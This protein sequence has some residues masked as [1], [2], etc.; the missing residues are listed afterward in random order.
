MM[1]KGPESVGRSISMGQCEAGFGDRQQGVSPIRSSHLAKAVDMED[2]IVIRGMKHH[3]MD[4]AINLAA[5]EG[6]NPGLNDA[7]CFYSTDPDGFFVALRDDAPVGCISAVSYGPEFGFIGFFVVVPELRGH[8]IGLDLGSAAMARLGDRNIGID[9]VEKKVKNYE[10]LGFKLAYRNIRYEGLSFKKN[11]S[12]QRHCVPAASLAVDKLA[13]YDRRFFPAPRPAFLSRWIAQAGATSFAAIDGDK[14]RGLGVIRPC[15]SGYKIGPLFADDRDRAELLF[16][17]LI[18]SI[19]EGMPFYMDPPET[20]ADALALCRSYRMK[21]VFQTARMY[22][23]TPPDI[24]VNNIYGV[25]SF[26]LG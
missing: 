18:A 23:K 8:R 15:R 13:Q 26:E 7:E 4:L 2:T 6:W 1:F 9:G 22:N 17:R 12:R 5:Q 3:E 14:I 11:A 20:N 25:T 24:E 21:P 16:A 10:Q 19:P